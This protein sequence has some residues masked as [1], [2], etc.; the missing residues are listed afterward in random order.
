MPVTKLGARL[1]EAAASGAVAA[2][3]GG[4]IADALS[5]VSRRI[6]RPDAQ[7]PNLRIPPTRK[8]I[9]DETGSLVKQSGLYSLVSQGIG[10]VLGRFAGP[11]MS[12]PG[13]AVKVGLPGVGVGMGMASAPDAVNP[14]ASSFAQGEQAGQGAQ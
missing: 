9:V 10:R 13:A 1:V 2:R 3:Q 7:F 11:R 12:L 14:A 8:K 6:T 4:G 5:F